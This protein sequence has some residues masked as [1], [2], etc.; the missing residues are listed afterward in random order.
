MKQFIHIV[1]LGFARITAAALVFKGRN[2]VTMLTGNPAYATPTP[3]LVTITAACDTLDSAV[4]AYDFTRSR[5]D[6]ETRD[7]AFFDLK[8]ML[9]ELGAYVQATSK[10]DRDLIL[11]AGFE[12]EKVPV[13]IGQL[14][15]PPN[16]RAEVT[17]YPGRIDV[18]WAGVRG[19]KIYEVWI[20]DG[21][22]SVEASWKLQGLTSKNRMEVEG[23][24]SNTV[25]Y[26][27]VVA[28]GAAGPSPVSDVANA[29]AA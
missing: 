22:P 17:A 12:T 19:R 2:N 10:G 29:K 7:V 3:T 24:T 16:V 4:Q 23:L 26:F 13:P 21:D 27:R 5:L 1:K 11:S 20:T 28:Q 14:P 6:K 18:K 8:A 25:Y 9:R 15:A